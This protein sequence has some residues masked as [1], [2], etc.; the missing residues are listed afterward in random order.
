MLIG[1]V[2]SIVKFAPLAKGVFGGEIDVFRIDLNLGKLNIGSKSWIDTLLVG[3]STFFGVVQLL[4][5]IVFSSRLFGKWS[6]IVGI[7]LLLSSISYILNVFSYAGRDGLV[8]WVLS[9]LVN[10]LL[11]KTFLGG[12]HINRL[13]AFLGLSV[14]LLLF[15]FFIITIARF[16]S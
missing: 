5:L 3:F 8:Y 13:N 12:Y 1:G 15:P 9:L 10:I 4:G 7:I 2:L 6:K 14:L 16:S 11:V